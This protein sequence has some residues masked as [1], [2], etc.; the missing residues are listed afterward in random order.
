MTNRYTN[1]VLTVIA[2]AL[3]TIAAQ[4]FLRPA[5]A[6]SG[7]ACGTAAKPCAVFNMTYEQSS[8]RWF[9]CYSVNYGCFYVAERR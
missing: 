9:P 3:S 8:S 5:E 1:I 6:Q 4:N 7:G 2:V